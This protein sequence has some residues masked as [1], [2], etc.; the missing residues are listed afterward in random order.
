MI[1][2]ILETANTLTLEGFLVTIDIRKALDSINHC[3][4][5]HIYPKFGFGID[6][7]SWIKTILKNQESCIINGEK[8]TKYFK[9]ERRSNEEIWFLCICL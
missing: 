1:S 8:T 2:D 7:A 5:L 4:L 9:S 3:L 6:S